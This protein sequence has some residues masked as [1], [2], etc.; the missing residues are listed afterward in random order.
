MLCST[1]LYM[2]HYGPRKKTNK[3]EHALLKMSFASLFLPAVFEVN[4]SIISIF[5]GIFSNI[6]LG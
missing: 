6:L 5:A 1:V 3:K 4:F 2:V